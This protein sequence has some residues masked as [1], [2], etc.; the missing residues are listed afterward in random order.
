MALCVP[1]PGS[2]LSPGSHSEVVP[3]LDTALC[4]SEECLSR[5]FFKQGLVA[6]RRF[7]GLDTAAHKWS[8]TDLGVEL[9]LACQLGQDD[10]SLA[11]R[12]PWKN[13]QSPN[14]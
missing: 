13:I 9:V 4:S 14:P 10:L 7:N 5:F 6:L 11:C 3:V 8:C 1:K 12:G 2:E